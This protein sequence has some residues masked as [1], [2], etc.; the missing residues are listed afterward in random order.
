VTARGSTAR[1]P[2]SETV[3]P[4]ILLVDDNDGKRLALRAMLEPLGHRVVEANS[5]QA[6]LR[7]VLRERF[8][9]ILMDV[10]MP[11]LSGYETARLIRDR[12]ASAPTPIIFITAFGRDETETE[13]AYASGA[14]DFVFA[15]VRADV[16]R[17]KV[18]VFVDLFIAA[19]EL[20]GSLDAITSLNA[21]LRD[22]ELRTQAVLD[23]VSDAIFILDEHG[24]IESVNR[25]VGRLFGY[26]PEQPLGQPFASVIAPE[27]RA[28][29]AIFKD[30]DI[31]QQLAK[32]LQL[33][34]GLETA[35]G[36]AAAK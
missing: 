23:N 24:L 10:R 16:L 9:L 31:Q 12:H 14:V 19:Q 29:F 33:T 28:D 2:E 13:S 7:A 36:S 6:A 1:A 26:E 25:S 35:E 3:A 5:G 21:A 4:A 8:A 11:T 20:Q 22:S 18:S 15:P 32:A 17:A 30:I 34:L 27:H